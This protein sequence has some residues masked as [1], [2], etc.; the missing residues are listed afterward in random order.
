MLLETSPD[1]TSSATTVHSYKSSTVMVQKQTHG[2]RMVS[3]IDER[4]MQQQPHDF[5]QGC[6]STHWRK[7]NIFI[8][9]H[10]GNQISTKENLN[11]SLS[12]MQKLQMHLRSQHKTQNFKTTGGKCMEYTSRRG[13]ISS[14]HLGSRARQFFVSSRP[15]W[16]V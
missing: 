13:H 2:Q 12:L 6:Q 5:S 3:T 7:D 15:A 9:L 16:S 14:Q 1:R 11:I 4:I 8:K 10:W